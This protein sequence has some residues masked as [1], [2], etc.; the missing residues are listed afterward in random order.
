M[1]SKD[2]GIIHSTGAII[3][4]NFALVVGFEAAETRRPMLCSR[5]SENSALEFDYLVRP[6]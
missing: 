5:G 4:E 2:K 3:H 1:S 6:L